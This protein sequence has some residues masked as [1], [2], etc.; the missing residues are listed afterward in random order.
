VLVAAGAGAYA[1]TSTPDLSFEGDGGAEAG[2]LPDGASPGD[3]SATGDSGGT[4][5]GSGGGDGGA[6]DGDAAQQADVRADAPPPFDGA[7]DDANTC[8]GTVPSDTTLCCNNVRCVGQST[9]QCNSACTQ[10]Q[11]LCNPNQF[12][13]AKGGVQC[14]ANAA[15][16][17]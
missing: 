2:I 8:P 14:K 17:P 16:C 5:D 9:G 15:Q 6:T 1:C 11:Q 10:C 7:I 12:C 4:S 13:C 3:S